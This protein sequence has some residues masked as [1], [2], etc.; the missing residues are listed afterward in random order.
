ME[1]FD[2]FV[3]GAIFTGIQEKIIHVHYD[4]DVIT[5]EETWIAG[6]L[7]DTMFLEASLEVIEEV[8]RGLLQTV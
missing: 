7:T 3:N 4:N 8:A 6:G 2:E 1:V 5:D